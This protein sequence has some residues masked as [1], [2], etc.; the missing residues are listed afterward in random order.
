M[1]DVFAVIIDKDPTANEVTKQYLEEN[2]KIKKFSQFIELNEGYDYVCEKLPDLVFID[3]EFGENEVLDVISKIYKNDN[4]CKIILTVKNAT[5]ELI[6]KAMK[7]GAKD[8]ISKPYIKR[9]FIETVNKL[10]NQINYKSEDVN[11]KVIS[12]FSNKGGIGKTTIAVNLAIETEN[13]T[14][15]PT[16]IVDFNSQFGDVST[17][18]NVKTNFGISYLL[19]NKDKINRDFLL[20][21]LP[22]YNK[23][24]N[25]YVLSDLFSLNDVKDLTLENVQDIIDALKSAFTYIIIDLTNVFDL[26]TM[27]ILDNSDE[28]LLPIVANIP[29]LRNCNRCLDLFKKIGYDDNKVKLILNRV[30][31]NDEI[32]SD[33]IEKT[34]EKRIYIKL[35]NDYFIVMSAINRGVGIDVI[36]SE[37]DI[38]KSFHKLAYSLILKKDEE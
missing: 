8:I 15:E 32:K 22:R 28:I 25:L 14:K 23:A 38:S 20:S 33:K 31:P 1:K 6:I 3:I 18:L 11:T 24:K 37:S 16:V 13:I 30:T 27:K 21:N 10:V 7:L 5:A 35:I 29:N 12:I 4:K 34:L 19:N 2:P 26:K 17:F 36:D 9:E